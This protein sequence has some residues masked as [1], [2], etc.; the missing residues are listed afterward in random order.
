M[1]MVRRRVAMILP[2]VAAVAACALAA[3]ATAAAASRAGTGSHSAAAPPPAF[4]VARFLDG[5]KLRHT[6]V[7]GGKMKSEPLTEPDDITVLT[8]N[9]YV[10]FQNG[11]GSEGQASGDGNADSTIVGV[12]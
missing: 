1:V 10:G 12:T 11:V 8:G 9:L 6:F 4:R 3:G 7:S 5:A 2:A